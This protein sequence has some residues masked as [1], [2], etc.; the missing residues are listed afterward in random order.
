MNYAIWG[1]LSGGPEDDFFHWG[2]VATKG[3]E[4]FLGEMGEPDSAR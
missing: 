3:K 2:W 4:K 1:G